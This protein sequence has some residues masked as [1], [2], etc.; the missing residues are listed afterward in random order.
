MFDRL[1]SFK[2]TKMIQCDLSLHGIEPEYRRHVGTTFQQSETACCKKTLNVLRQALKKGT[3][4]NSNFVHEEFCHDE[5]DE[6][7]VWQVSMPCG[8]LLFS[9]VIDLQRRSRNPSTVGSQRMSKTCSSNP[10]VSSSSSLVQPA[11][12]G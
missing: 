3:T 9:P 4:M 8:F 5:D 1:L 2:H 10:S 11:W 7:G 12:H 6:D